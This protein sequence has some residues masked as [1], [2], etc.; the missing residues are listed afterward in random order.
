MKKKQRW[1]RRWWGGLR[2]KNDLCTLEFSACLAVLSSCNKKDRA[3][4]FSDIWYDCSMLS[5]LRLKTSD[6]FSS[7]GVTKAALFGSNARGEQ[8]DESDIDILVELGK[9]LSLFDYVGLK[10][11]LEDRLGTSVDLVQYK[12]VKPSL[13]KYILG[14]EKVFYQE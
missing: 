8:G 1:G 10:L 2:N 7:Y 13:K 6:I 9:D 11:D 5:D 3:E 12:M 4:F 14:S